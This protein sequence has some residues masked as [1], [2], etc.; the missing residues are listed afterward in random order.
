MTNPEPHGVERRQIEQSQRRRDRN[1]AHQRGCHRTE[2]IAAQ[3][4]YQ[5]Q[6]GGHCRQ[7]DRTEAP[8]CRTDDG[9]HGAM[10]T[11]NVLLDLINQDHGISHDDA[12]HRDR[13]QL[14]DETKGF[15]EQQQRQDDTDQSER[16]SKESTIN[17]R[18]KLCSC[19]I[20]SVSTAITSSGICANMDACALAFSSTEPPMSMR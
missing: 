11:A 8:H 12:E 6:H 1:P 16:R 9:P 20:N 13:A 4:R 14:G 19:I 15:A 5:R 7:G 10:T 2:E 18:L 17:T 3:Q